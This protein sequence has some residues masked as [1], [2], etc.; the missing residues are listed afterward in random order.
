[1]VLY[2]TRFTAEACLAVCMTATV[3]GWGGA[4]QMSGAEGLHTVPLTIQ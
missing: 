4:P 2:G 1:M 3:T